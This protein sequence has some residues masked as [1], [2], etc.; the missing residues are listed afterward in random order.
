MKAEFI[1]CSGSKNLI[2]FFAGWA[3]DA[4]PF[5]ELRPKNAD[6][7]IVSDYSDMTFDKSIIEHYD[8]IKLIGWSMGVYAASFVFRNNDERITY[9]IAI[10]GT[11]Y[12]IDNE[13]GIAENIFNGTLEGLNEKSLEKF[14][15][16]MCGSK[17][18][19]E[20]YIK[21]QPQ[22][23]I[24]DIRNELREI[25]N[26]YNIYGVPRFTWDMA[27]IGSGDKIFLPENQAR[28]YGKATIIIKNLE[29][30]YS[31]QLLNVVING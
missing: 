5:K 11:K 19:F 6:L 18:A 8:Y 9:S 12:P 16:R 27:I 24:E 1:Y 23:D 3:M 22:R 17:A 4:S 31:H 14:Q 28:A 20:N 2:L 15:L 10:N 21:I 25:Q 30:H 29:P 26:H 13:R 7:M